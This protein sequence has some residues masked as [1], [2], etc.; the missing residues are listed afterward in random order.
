MKIDAG[1]SHHFAA[2]PPRAASSARSAGAS[3]A[4]TLAATQADST[5]QT[6]STRQADFT[7]MTR[8]EMRDWVNAW[9]RSG[10]MSLDESRPLVAMT[11]RIP[12]GGA[13]GVA[14]AAGNDG[15]RI[16]FTQ[17]VRDGIQGAL[18]RI[19]QTTLNMLQSA[20]SIMLDQQGR[21]IGIDSHA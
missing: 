4:A 14:P 10:D 16:D 18:S 1:T 15:T 17:L 2:Q 11:M 12:V 3:F 20:M 7:S 19:D 6:D 21:T 8:Q 9:I 13:A 5:R